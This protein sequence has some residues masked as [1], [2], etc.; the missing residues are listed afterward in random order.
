MHE[1]LS[2]RTFL[3]SAASVAAGTALTGCVTGSGAAG[4][5]VAAGTRPN[6]LVLFTDQERQQVPHDR[7]HL[8]N[9]AR[10]QRNGVTF[11]RAFCATP[12]CSASRANLLTGLYPTEA[13]VTANM[14]MQRVEG[15][16]AALPARHPT[17]ATTLR[18]VGYRTGY[19]G[20]WHLSE[21]RPPNS[22]EL[23]PH[24]F[25]TYEFKRREEAARAAVDWIGEK[26]SEPWCMMVSFVD[27]HDIYSISR[28]RDYPIRDDVEALSNT[29]DDLSA[30]P[31]PQRRYLEEDQGKVS[32]GWDETE[33]RR[34]LSLY[35]D[36]IEGLDRDIGV[37]LD[38]LETMGCAENTVI[39]YASDHG[40]LGGAHGLPYK[41]PCMYEELLRVPLI[42]SSP[43]LGERPRS[44]DSL[45]QLGD[46]YPTICELA[47]APP[48]EGLHGRSLLPFFGRREPKWRDAIFAEYCGKQKWV[49]PIRTVRTHDLKYNRYTDGYDELYDLN[50]DPGELRNLAAD[51]GYRN[52]R[53]ELRRRLDAWRERLGD[54]TLT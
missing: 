9:R 35:Y 49:V 3:G 26:P 10:L 23:V 21:Q 27:P 25:D 41:G 8:P 12:Q 5:E 42:V 15:R 4:P 14:L 47:G 19:I 37:V 2:R 32:I 54:P 53:N 46:V 11:N 36:L 28:K 22:N 29:F 1:K 40:D 44:T 17:F 6:I 24:G 20:K 13:D 30:K 34:Y 18:G 52:K 50:R 43:M 39:V 7:L 16:Q 33:W 31:P 45:V 38:G 48:P 51:P